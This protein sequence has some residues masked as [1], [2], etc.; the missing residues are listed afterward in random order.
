M[1]WTVVF[2]SI[3]TQTCTEREA[4]EMQS[5]RETCSPSLC[6]PVS[7]W[8]Q[9]EKD[10]NTPHDFGLVLAKIAFAA[11]RLQMR[12][13]TPLPVETTFSKQLLNLK[14]WP[15]FT[16]TFGTWRTIYSKWRDWYDI[17][18]TYI[19]TFPTPPLQTGDIYIYMYTPMP[20]EWG[21]RLCGR[22]QIRPFKLKSC[23]YNKKI[24]LKRRPVQTYTTCICRTW[25]FAV[26]TS[27]L[28]TCLSPNL[29]QV[30]DK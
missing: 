29:I 9:R 27:L 13:L 17:P 16:A 18:H 15:P 23:H 7:L 3:L 26:W 21:I 1:V 22:I 8:V 12:S 20:P 5:D 28:S 24:L 10:Q 2:R 14:L 11:K 25:G 4:L 19:Y 6:L 30:T